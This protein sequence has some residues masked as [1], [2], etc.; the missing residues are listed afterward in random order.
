MVCVWSC[1]GCCGVVGVWAAGRVGGKSVGV[2]Y[3][4]GGGEDRRKNVDGVDEKL[5]LKWT[6]PHC[7]V[8]SSR[9]SLSLG[10]LV[11]SRVSLLESHSTIQ[12]R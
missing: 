7:T 8:L 4:L 10:S 3:V 1:C 9:T 5:V 6:S 12:P 2:T 11:W